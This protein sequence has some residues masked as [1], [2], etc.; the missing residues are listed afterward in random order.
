[1]KVNIKE[2][3]PNADY[4]E[5]LKRGNPIDKPKNA[6][7]EVGTLMY[8]KPN[9]SIG[10]ILGCIDEEFDG[11]VRLDSDGMQSID[12]LRLA[13]PTDFKIEGVRFKTDLDKVI[14]N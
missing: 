5:Y 13:K 2:Y 6:T 7:L 1:M 8:D 4:T 9:N 11:D 3:Y 12:S 10:M 14:F